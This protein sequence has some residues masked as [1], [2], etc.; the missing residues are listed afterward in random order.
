MYKGFKCLDVATRRVYIS[1]DVLFDEQVF[2]FKGLHE[3]ARVDLSKKF[4]YFPIIF[5]TIHKGCN[6]YLFNY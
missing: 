4:C 2:P 5:S 6:L 1:Q 3:S